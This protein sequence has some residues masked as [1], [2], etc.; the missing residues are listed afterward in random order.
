MLA[1]YQR[2]VI[3]MRNDYTL[4]V[5]EA[6]RFTSPSTAAFSFICAARPTVLS[7]AVRIGQ[8]RLTWE[9]DLQVSQTDLGDGLTELTFATPEPVSGNMYTFNFELP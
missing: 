8:I 3:S 2:T 9:G 6:L 7:T 5:V 1:S 4:R